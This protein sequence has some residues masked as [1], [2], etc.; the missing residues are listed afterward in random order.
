MKTYYRSTAISL[1]TFA[2]MSFPSLAS[3]I[4]S[5]PAPSNLAVSPNPIPP[6]I[7]INKVELDSRLVKASTKFG[8]NLFN[9]IFQQNPHKNI[10]ISPS[11]VAIALAMTYNGANG[12][13][14]S[15]MARTLELEGIST[16]D[17]NNFNQLL[18]VSLLDSQNDTEISIANSLWINQ[19]IALER[20]FVEKL[21]TYYQATIKNLNF[22][23]SSSTQII[24]DWVKQQTKNKIHQIVKRASNDTVVILINAIYFKAN[25]ANAFDKSL[26]NLKPFT[27]ENGTTIQHPSMSRLGEYRYLDRPKF[28]AVRIPYQNRRFRMDIF[29]PKNTSSLAEFQQQL[30]LQ[31]W[32]DWSDSFQ[33]NTGLVQ[34]P[35]FKVEYE[36]E[37]NQVL[38]S[39]GMQIAF[40]PSADFRNLTSSASSISEVRHKTFV[41]VNEEGTEASAATSVRVFRGASRTFQMIIDRP[42]FFAISDRQTGTIL[43]MGT[44]QNPALK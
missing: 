20:S 8:F 38:K 10:F 32:Q 33:I 19:N 43:F 42:F 4:K 1:L 34:L 24:N 17:I 2:M 37:L 22:D 40:S 31:N 44:I 30:T 18:Q 13:T 7:A 36:L 39:L 29:L 25:W 41:D 21:K 12:Q 26:T 15:A 5:I 28:Q 23:D 11:S 14:Q 35:R 6:K 3:P 16:N 9:Q 27:L